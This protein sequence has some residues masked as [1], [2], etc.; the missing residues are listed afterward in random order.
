MT[1]LTG[2]I[3]QPRTWLRLLVLI[4]VPIVLTLMFTHGAWAEEC[5]SVEP[6]T[7]L[8]LRCTPPTKTPDPGKV[9]GIFDVVD[10][11]GVPISSYG[12]NVDS[13]GML[14]V[15][16]KIISFLI[17]VGFSV[18]RTVIGFACWLVDWALDFGLAKTLLTPVSDIAATVKDQVIDNLA[19]KTLFLTIVALWGGYL[20]LF[21]QRSKGWMEIC[22][23]L[24]VASIATVTLASPGTF[25]IGNGDDTGVLGK[26]KE[27]SLEIADVILTQRCDDDTK[28]AEPDSDGKKIEPTTCSGRDDGREKGVS[29][30]ITD[31]L[32]DAFIQRPI[33]VL[34]TGKGISKEC[35]Y[36]YGQ[37]TLARYNFNRFVLPG[38]VKKEQ[39]D[40]SGWLDTLG[41]VFAN[42]FSLDGLAKNLLAA[43]GNPW[44]IYT[45]VDDA[46][47]AA[48]E[49]FKKD[50]VKS[51]PSWKTYIDGEGSKNVKGT[52]PAVQDAC[53]GDVPM[54]DQKISASLDNLLSVWFIALAAIIVV[55]LVLAVSCTFL[56]SQIW[57][58]VE[59][60]RAQPALV[61]GIL[62]GGG[63]QMMWKWVSGVV[64]VILAVFLSVMFLAFFLVMI[65]AVLDA[66]TGQVMT[67][68]FLSIDFIAL[69]FL[70]FRKKV[71]AAAK[72]V[73]A[74]FG[75]KMAA[76][77][78]GEA[79]TFK[80]AANGSPSALDQFKKDGA[81][82]SKVGG[83]TRD[84]W[85]GKVPGEESEGE[86]EGE[87][88]DGGKAAGKGAGQKKPKKGLKDRVQGAV[89]LGT[90]VAAAVGTGGTSAALQTSAKAALKARLKNAAKK[91]AANARKAAT[92]RL[93]KSRV[94]RATL[95]T[96]RTGRYLAKDAPI[97]RSRFKNAV[98]TER[99][100][101]LRTRPEPSRAQNLSRDASRQMRQTRSQQRSESQRL[102]RAVNGRRDQHQNRRRSTAGRPR[103]RRP[104]SGGGGGS[105][106]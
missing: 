33:W 28:Q 13:G 43:T 85:R 79:S 59:V 2:V 32:V 26:T 97:T 3:R 14:D 38:L 24:V 37:A 73:S 106:A 23:S 54:D 90:T 83:K 15:I 62:P 75:Q 49:K 20:I 29:R 61:A 40:S 93:N 66:D 94:G 39:K 18:I 17:G 84:L 68:K 50:V 6:G 22:T 100:N 41:K 48:I 102:N 81:T 70:V 63:R 104:R 60:I 31:G 72:N 21:K 44:A 46:Q 98:A 78:G 86:G 9:M 64:R 52:D 10:R 7:V 67:I 58:A 4:G 16:S 71:T 103:A 42:T 69:G 88:G 65:I 27:F 101:L 77:T 1:A 91:R 57:M 82:F 87:G 99:R 96:A 47:Q 19:L 34:Y 8:D 30:P 12:L 36:A 45:A 11:N 35:S 5:K 25:L 92:Q 56:M 53:G 76:K 51:D 105:G 95:A 74:N 55:A 80:G 89:K